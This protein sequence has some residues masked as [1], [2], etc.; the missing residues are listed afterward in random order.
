MVY[1]DWIT[2]VMNICNFFVMNVSPGAGVQN[3]VGLT[4]GEILFS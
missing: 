4:A 2:T 3:L 1:L